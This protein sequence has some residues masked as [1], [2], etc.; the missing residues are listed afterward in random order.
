MEQ[1]KPLH[2]KNIFNK[3]TKADYVDLKAGKWTFPIEKKPT[4]LS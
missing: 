3:I 2:E 1:G 4:F